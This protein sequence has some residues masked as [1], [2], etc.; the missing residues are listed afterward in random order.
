VEPDIRLRAHGEAALIELDRLQQQPG[1]E[2][3]KNLEQ[4][5]Q[6][7]VDMRNVLI[8][9]GACRSGP[10]FDDRLT[11]INAILS[12]LFGTE[13]PHSGLQW[14]RICESREALRNLLTST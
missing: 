1:I 9:A 13:F 2:M 5:M 7:L 12:C 10:A 8:E 14:R 3:Q 11:A 4:V 6:H